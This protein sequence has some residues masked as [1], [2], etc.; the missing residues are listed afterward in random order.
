[1]GWLD[2]IYR[3]L[4]TEPSRYSTLWAADD[5]KRPR[6]DP[7]F[8]GEGGIERIHAESAGWPHW[9]HLLAETIVDLCND[10]E[11]SQ[12]DANLLKN[13]PDKAIVAGDTVVRQLMPPEDATPAEWAYTRAFRARDTQPPP[14]NEAVYRALRRRLLVMEDQGQWRLRVPLMQRWLRERG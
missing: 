11:Q 14:D 6:F 4:L 10:R 2:L 7:D 5:F 12:V 9:V 8:W 13:A 3:R 1:M